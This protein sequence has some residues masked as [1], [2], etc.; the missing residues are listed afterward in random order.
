MSWRAGG[1]PMKRVKERGF[2]PSELLGKHYAVTSDDGRYVIV[3]AV[4]LDPKSR[5]MTV[6]EVKEYDTMEEAEKALVRLGRRERMH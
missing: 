4:S 5:T 3:K 2:D 6:K 1:S